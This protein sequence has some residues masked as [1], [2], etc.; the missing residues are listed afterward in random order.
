MWELVKKLLER[1]K[2]VFHIAKK[3]A[4]DISSEIKDK[5]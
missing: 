5:E 3:A 4:T 1:I 2:S